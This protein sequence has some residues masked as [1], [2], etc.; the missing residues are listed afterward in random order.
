[1]SLSL[2]DIYNHNYRFKGFPTEFELVAD[3]LLEEL[4]R[5]VGESNFVPYTSIL[6]RNIH[7]DEGKH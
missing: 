7:L 4:V 5:V 1:M 2:D 6:K 3:A